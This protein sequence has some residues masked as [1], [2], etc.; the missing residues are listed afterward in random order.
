MAK[1]QYKLQNFSRTPAPF[2]SD[3]PTQQLDLLADFLRL[4]LQG[5]DVVP[6]RL[7]L[8]RLGQSPSQSLT[9]PGHSVVVSVDIH[10]NSRMH[11]YLNKWRGSKLGDDKAQTIN[12][13]G[14]ISIREPV[15]VQSEIEICTILKALNRVFFLKLLLSLHPTY[16]ELMHYCS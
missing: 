11:C 15:S 16:I 8:G 4:L 3:S 12:M 13:N 2:T 1:I 10:P 14:G 7:Q 6:L 9:L 5:L